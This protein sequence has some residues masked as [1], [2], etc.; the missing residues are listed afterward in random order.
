[1]LLLL[2]LSTIL[3]KERD[4]FQF[5]GLFLPLVSNNEIVYLQLVLIQLCTDQTVDLL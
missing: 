5:A 2:F 3:N 1:M 4:N